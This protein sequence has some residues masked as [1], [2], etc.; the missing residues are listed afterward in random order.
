MKLTK[1]RLKR[2][3][4]EELDI[5]LEDIDA[6]DPTADPEL[7][8][9]EAGTEEA[10]REKEAREKAENEAAAQKVES[11]MTSV[12]DREVYAAVL[13]NVLLGSQLSSSDKIKAFQQLFGKEEGKRVHAA[14]AKLAPAIVR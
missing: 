9:P 1:S 8:D 10:E 12:R 2:I 3:I 4:K 14:I 11:A 5:I 6:L 13:K 7:A